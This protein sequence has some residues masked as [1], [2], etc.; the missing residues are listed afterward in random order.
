ML[1]KRLN[2]RGDGKAIVIILLIILIALIVLAIWFFSTHGFGFGNG[3]GN[4][5]ISSN[6]EDGD[7][8]QENASSDTEAVTTEESKTEATTEAGDINEITIK[9]KEDKVWVNDKEI[10][11]KDALKS[12]LEE[13]NDDNKKYTLEQ[14]DAI[15]A[16]YNWVVEVLDELKIE[17]TELKTETIED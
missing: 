2:N 8:T 1:K 12:Y 10:A 4:G 14:E 11:D 9:I 17:Y 13:I 7:G 16:T 5:I 15:L 6:S 3:N